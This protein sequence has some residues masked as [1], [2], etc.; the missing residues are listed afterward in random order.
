MIAGIIKGDIDRKTNASAMR[1]DSQRA[2]ALAPELGDAEWPRAL[3]RL[4]VAASFDGDIKTTRQKTSGRR[5]RARRRLVTCHRK[6]SS[7]HARGGIVAVE[8]VSAGSAI[9]GERAGARGD[10]AG[11]GC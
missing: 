6:L 7:S 10:P 1:R 9:D 4:G 3:A 8:D 11:Y 5:C 2:A